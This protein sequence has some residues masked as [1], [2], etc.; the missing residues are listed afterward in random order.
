MLLLEFSLQ[1]A[2]EPRGSANSNVLVS[3][4]KE[5]SECGTRARRRLIRRKLTTDNCKLSICNCSIVNSL[6]PLDVRRI[7]PQVFEGIIQPRVRVEYVHDDVAVILHNPARGLVA[8]D[9]QPLL[10]GV[11][12]GGVDF[13]GEGMNLATAGARGQ[14]LE[15]V[16]RSN[17]S[18]VE[19]N[20]ILGLVLLGDASTENGTFEAGFVPGGRLCFHGCD[21]QRTSFHMRG[22][23]VPRPARTVA[24]AG[25]IC[26]SLGHLQTE[27]GRKLGP[28]RCLTR[29][30]LPLAIRGRQ[31][32]RRISHFRGLAELPW[33]TVTGPE[34][35][36][37]KRP[38]SRRQTLRNL[39]GLFILRNR[40]AEARA[41]SPRGLFRG[42]RSTGGQVLWK[43]LADL[44]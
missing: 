18:H 26:G 3:H 1:A 44:A 5:K 11:R 42:S 36:D 40:N 25:A 37:K 28:A 12:Q 41:F 33:D 8:L 7:G 43:P 6:S 22:L 23:E 21:V 30:Y 13:F 4:G 9:G 39:T 19:D 35:R 15:V 14:H 27:Q 24:L 38:E 32:S 2:V 17:A 20:D 31:A 10:A 16:E 34:V 29:P